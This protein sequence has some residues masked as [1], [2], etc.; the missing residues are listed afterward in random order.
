MSREKKHIRPIMAY[1]KANPERYKII[2]NF[3][4]DPH[5]KATSTK[6]RENEFYWS[7]CVFVAS[8]GT[9]IKL[10]TY[11]PELLD[12]I[13]KELKEGTTDKEI[14]DWAEEKIKENPELLVKSEPNPFYFNPIY[15]NR[16]N[17]GTVTELGRLFLTGWYYNIEEWTYEVGRYVYRAY[18]KKRTQGEE[19]NDLEYKNIVSHIRENIGYYYHNNPDLKL[20]ILEKLFSKELQPL[21][22]EKPKELASYDCAMDL[23]TDIHKARLKKDKNWY[24][25]HYNQIEEYVGYLEEILDKYGIE[26]K[27]QEEYLAEAEE[28][29]KKY[30]QG[31]ENLQREYREDLLGKIKELPL[32]IER[33]GRGYNLNGVE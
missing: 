29:N 28:E 10:Y 26:Y 7:Y 20:Y 33:G 1:K 16:V 9:D 6:G 30:F 15:Q 24:V 22:P 18:H 12:L 8:W 3:F 13:R 5:T 32:H 4:V 27:D 19:F 25:K 31:I 14:N 23:F 17:I 21:L 11:S 2:N